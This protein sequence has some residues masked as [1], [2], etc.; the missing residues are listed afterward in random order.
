MLHFY[1]I[2]PQT[3]PFPEKR[4]LGLFTS[5]KNTFICRF[6]LSAE[7]F[8]ILKDFILKNSQFWVAFTTKELPLI[9]P[10]NTHYSSVKCSSTV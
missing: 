1:L 4:A 5:H 6:G 10:V 7:T 2:I 9:R 3:V 8:Q